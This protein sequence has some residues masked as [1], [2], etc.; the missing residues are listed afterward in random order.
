MT[1]VFFDF[2]EFTIPYSRNTMDW[3]L[4]LA[5]CHLRKRRA[6]RRPLEL[7]VRC[8]RRARCS[9]RSA[10]PCS[11]RMRDTRTTWT[12]CTRRRS[13]SATSVRAS[14]P[15]VASW[16]VTCWRTVASV[17]L[18]AGSADGASCCARCC[19]DTC[20]LCT[21]ASVRT[22]A[23][24]AG[25][26]LPRSISLT[27]TWRSIADKPEGGSPAR[28]RWIQIFSGFVDMPWIWIWRDPASEDP[29]CVWKSN[30][31]SVGFEY[32]VSDVSLVGYGLL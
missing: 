18:S 17:A 8:G 14:A 5:V 9:A 15:V 22:C 11:R 2:S 23:I 28:W 31:D 16:R 3:C 10:G 25:D 29:V 6:P 4:Q 1:K 21:H 19:A 12:P 27:P 7:Q 13:L 24:C 32:S 26:P 30:V 20:V